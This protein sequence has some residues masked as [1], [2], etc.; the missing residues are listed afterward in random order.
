MAKKIKVVLLNDIL[1]D[2]EV[3]K[4]TDVLDKRRVALEKVYA[5]GNIIDKGKLKDSYYFIVEKQMPFT[6]VAPNKYKSPSGRTFTKKQVELYHASDGFKNLSK[7]I[8]K[9]KKKK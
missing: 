5:Q 1:I 2:P 4:V 7:R 8:G 6:K 3:A 9:L